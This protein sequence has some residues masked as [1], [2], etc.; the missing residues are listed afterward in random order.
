LAETAYLEGNFQDV[1][2]NLPFSTTDG[3]MTIANKMASLEQMTI[4]DTLSLIHHDQLQKAKQLMLQA[5]KIVIFASNSNT[6]ISQDFML[7]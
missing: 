4:H 5:K 6:L 7:K 1:D 2:A 3:I